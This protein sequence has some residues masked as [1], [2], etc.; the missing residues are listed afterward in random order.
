MSRAFVIEPARAGD[1]EAILAVMRPWN[2]HHVPSPEMEELDLAAFFVARLDGDIVGAS[3]YKIL[4]PTQ[5]KTTLLAVLPE[6]AGTGIG[7]ALQHK[8]LEAMHRLGVKRV[9]TNADRPATIRWYKD[10]F[11]YKEVGELLK[12]SEFGDPQIDRWTTL[13]LD[14]EGYM[15]RADAAGR[16]PSA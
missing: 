9:T 11:G 4:S 14:L 13:E 8:R 3:G 12:V 6:H 15:R 1:R 7:A 16:E 2:M 10:R 5:G